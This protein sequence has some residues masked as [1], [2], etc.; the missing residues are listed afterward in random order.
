MPVI[1]TTPPY[2]FNLFAYA[3][4]EFYAN[5][6]ASITSAYNVAYP[7][8]TE[9]AAYMEDTAIWARDFIP[10]TQDPYEPISDM[11]YPL[12]QEATDAVDIFQDENY[13]IQN[14]TMHGFLAISF[15]WRNMLN[16]ILSPG[17]NGTV[18]V[19]ENTCNPPFSY[20]ING[21][22]PQYLGV[23]DRHDPK[24]DHLER[25]SSLL[26]LRKFAIKDN[27]YTGA[28]VADTPDTC[29]YFVRIYPSDEMEEIFMTSNP[30]ILSVSAG[31]IFLVFAAAFLLY[32]KMVGRRQTLVM[33]TAERSATIVSSMFPESVAKR[34]MEDENQGAFLSQNRRLKSFLNDGSHDDTG[35]LV[36]KPIADL[37]PFSTVLFADICG[38]TAWSSTRDPSQVFI[39]L[40]T[41]YKAFDDLASA[42]K[43]FKVETVGDCYVAVTGLPN[44]QDNHAVLMARFATG[45]LAKF[46]ELVR[47]MEATLG[48]DTADLRIRFGIHRYVL[49]RCNCTVTSAFLV[50]THS[51][52]LFPTQWTSHSRCLE[53]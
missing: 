5:H 24:Y 28:P 3:S 47:A 16:D 49:P 10:A 41:I 11:Y 8:D 51:V 29:P 33:N 22:S 32:D 50:L 42:R 21:P 31:G 6:T 19:F 35:L 43:V 37:F 18:L 30:I 23:G 46:N 9:R 25:S 15:F 36:S 12:L 38:F 13:D 4:P 2:N 53:R 52:C 14:Q 34:M 39:L 40:E 45:C 26:D 1:P 48:P 27:G 7:N 17:S 20:Q 44:P